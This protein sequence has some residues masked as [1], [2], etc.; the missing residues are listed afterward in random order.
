MFDSLPTDATEAMNWSWPQ[1]EPFYDDLIGRS[2]SMKLSPDFS[3]LDQV[4]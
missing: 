4:E 1:F 3:R 2:V